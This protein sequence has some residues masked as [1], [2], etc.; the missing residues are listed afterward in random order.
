ME[1]T[2]L[3][4]ACLGEEVVTQPLGC[5]LVIGFVAWS[6]ERV[7]IS[8]FLFTPITSLQV[9]ILGHI[10]LRSGMTKADDFLL[11]GE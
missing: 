1:T 10:I 9:Y 6:L 3:G 11:L 2:D 5:S 4:A 8:V 7:I